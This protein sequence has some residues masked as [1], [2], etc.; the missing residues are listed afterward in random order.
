MDSS[1]LPSFSVMQVIL[2]KLNMIARAPHLLGLVCS[3]VV[4]TCMTNSFFDLFSR[5]TGIK[6]VRM[7]GT[8]TSKGYYRPCVGA[9]EM[10]LTDRVRGS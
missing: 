3:A 6:L 4:D 2:A 8:D 9:L 1:Q 5:G 7:K 10:P